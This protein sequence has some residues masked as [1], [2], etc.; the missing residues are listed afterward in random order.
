MLNTEFT[1]FK[2][3]KLESFLSCIMFFLII[4]IKNY[5]IYFAWMVV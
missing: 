5:N 4:F 2:L 1:N 3:L